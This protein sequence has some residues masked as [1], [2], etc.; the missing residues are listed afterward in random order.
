MKKVMKHG[1]DVTF[2][3]ENLRPVLFRYLAWQASTS[4]LEQNFSKSDFFN[5]TGKT[6]ASDEFEAR[7]VRLLCGD[8]D[9]NKIVEQAQK[10]YSECAPGQG[11]F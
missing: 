3:T 8:F 11:L 1:R 2:P 9:Q 7:S 4:G 6:G 10:L 5:V